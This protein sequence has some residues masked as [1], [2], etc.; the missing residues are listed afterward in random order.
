MS[1][2]LNRTCPASKAMRSLVKARSLSF[3]ASTLAKSGMRRKRST[4]S[5][6]LMRVP[7]VTSIDWPSF[8]LNERAERG[9]R[10]VELTIAAL[11]DEVPIGHHQDAVE[12]ARQ[13]GAMEDPNQAALGARF[14]D[15]FHHLAL[16]GAV[17]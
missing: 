16:G 10:S 1:P 14:L 7:S 9:S 3:E 15:A 2:W 12:M 17:E 4:S 8:R 6:R 11:L 13:A 5:L